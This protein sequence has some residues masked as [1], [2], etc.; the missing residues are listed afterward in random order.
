VF[1]ECLPILNILLI[2]QKSCV[3]VQFLV[4]ESYAVVFRCIGDYA[5]NYKTRKEM[6]RVLEDVSNDSPDLRFGQLIANL[7]YLAKGPASEAI[8]DIE[9]QELL[10]AARKYL[11]DRLG[12]Q[13]T[14]A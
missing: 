7:S 3:P 1:H 13:S 4:L 6:L 2:L 10:A 12:R 11:H 8:W 5:G 9:D 14:A